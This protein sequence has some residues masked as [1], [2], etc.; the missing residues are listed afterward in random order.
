[1]S[2]SLAINRLSLALLPVVLALAGA[3]TKPNPDYCDGKTL[4]SGLRRCVIETHTCA[5]L[6]ASTA[7][8]APPD[9]AAD[10]AR[11]TAPDASADTAPEVRAPD[12][13]GS[14]S[15]NAD[16][17]A[18]DR[19]ACVNNQC[20]PCTGN[21]HCKMGAP[22]CARD[23]GRCVACTA[24]DGCEDSP[25]TPVCI[26][27]RCA[28]CVAGTDA[29]KMRYTDKPVC[30]ATGQCVG[31]VEAVRDCPLPG[32][33]IC[34]ASGCVACPDDAACA[35]RNA[36][37][38][39][40]DLPA[41]A[42]V[43]CV[44]DKHCTDPTKPICDT[45]ARRCVGC[46]SDAQCA[47]KLGASVPGICMSHQDGRCATDAE[48]IHVTNGPGCS[49]SGGGTAAA[50]FCQTDAAIGAVT[51][52]RRVILLKGPEALTPFTASPVGAPISIIGQLGATIAPGAFVGVRVTAGEVYIRGVTVSGSTQTGIIVENGAVLRLERATLTGNRGGLLVLN[53]GYDVSNTI[54]ASNKGA[55][56]PNT[57]TSYGGAYLRSA[58]GKPAV[59]RNN[60]IVDNEVIGLV[61]ADAY[62]VKN[63]LVANNAVEQVL[64]CAPV[65]SVV[66]G[67]PR[68]NPARPYHLTG[69]S[70]CVAA[71]DPMDFPAHDFDGDARPLPAGTRSDCGADELAQ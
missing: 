59:F 50:P 28:A 54:I 49:A 26:A 17:T 38:P 14:C 61:C 18:D 23:T 2:P 66:G 36:A 57:A 64:T 56:V 40:C 16:C 67:D 15:T 62:Q 48:V 47:A 29:C 43:Q 19:P 5:E 20:V 3:C 44:Q 68:F 63:L 53:A 42:C 70:P 25:A 69:A 12:A 13:A 39:A 46:A 10:V 35:M 45:Q 21:N 55:L 41:G 58:P 6:D 37:T 8:D 11:D 32:K 33:P 71:G 1:M 31:C 65:T 30:G 9:V 34:R 22:I 4:C 27:G 51:A 24:T 60:T 52:T 7:P